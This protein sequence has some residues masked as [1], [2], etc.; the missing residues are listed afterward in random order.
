MRNYIVTWYYTRPKGDPE[1][2]ELM[3]VLAP[4]IVDII[5]PVCCTALVRWELSAHALGEKLMSYLHP[6]DKLLVTEVSDN[7]AWYG[8]KPEET[9]ALCLGRP[10]LPPPPTSPRSPEHTV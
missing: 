9:A 6:D 1:C 10:S 8:L 4:M 3:R 5:D 2:L 7:N